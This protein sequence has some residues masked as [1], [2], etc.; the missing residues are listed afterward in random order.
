VSKYIF[1]IKLIFELPIRLIL[2]LMGYILSPFIYLFRY[3]D[4]SIWNKFQTLYS[5]NTSFLKPIYGNDED[6]IFFDPLVLKSKPHLLKKKYRGT[7]IDFFVW[8]IMRNP[9]HN[10]ELNTGLKTED[11]ID[12]KVEKYKS[13]RIEKEWYTA[14]LKDGSK[15]HFLWIKISFGKKYLTFYYGPRLTD[16]VELDKFLTSGRHIYYKFFDELLDAYT[17]KYIQNRGYPIVRNA[18]AFRLKTIR[19]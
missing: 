13:G 4:N 3:R 6:G 16:L 19:D 1:Y 2:I 11:I 17:G 14:V 18:M 8:N 12:L 5:I 7:F 15:K 10:Y 9:I